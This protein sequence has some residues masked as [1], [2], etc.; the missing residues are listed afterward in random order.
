MHDYEGKST[1]EKEP[2]QKGF[3]PSSLWFSAHALL[4]FGFVFLWHLSHSASSLRS[5]V[6]VSNAFAFVCQI[7]YWLSWWN[8][9]VTTI[10]FVAFK[11]WAR[12]P[13]LLLQRRWWWQCMHRRTMAISA[14]VCLS[15]CLALVQFTFSFADSNFHLSETNECGDDVFF[16][17]KELLWNCTVHIAHWNITWR[18]A[19]LQPNLK[20]R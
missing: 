8:F 15:V 19:W 2:Q 12:M 7:T 14:C 3:L 11:I 10:D 13:L 1:M 17:V 18:C 4:S 9:I 16:I 6:R 20:L 5:T